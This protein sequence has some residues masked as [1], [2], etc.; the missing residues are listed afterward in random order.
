MNHP[1]FTELALAL[2]LLTPLA[3]ILFIAADWLRYG[4]IQ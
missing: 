4:G 2:I 3:A 1:A